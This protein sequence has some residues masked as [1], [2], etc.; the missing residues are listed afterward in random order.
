MP[1][2]SLFT[3]GDTIKWRDSS[4]LNWLNESVTSGDYTLKYYMRSPGGDAHTVTGTAWGTGWEFEIS[5]MYSAEFDP[6]IWYFKSV[7]TKSSETVTLDSGQF[8]VKESLTY[9]GSSPGPYDGRTQVKKDLDDVTAAIRSIIKDKAKS[10]SIGNRTFTR[11]DL[12]ELR[13]R[14]SQLK[15]EVVRERKADMIA[16]GLGDP[17]SLYVRFGGN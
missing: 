4:S 5:A 11:L 14:E 15:A 1:I 12:P 16:N 6:G 8:E 13:S 17:H 9:T 10:Y 3:S 2:P 7:A